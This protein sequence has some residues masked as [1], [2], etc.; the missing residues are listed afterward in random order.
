[1]KKTLGTLMAIV[2]AIVM[3]FVMTGCAD[4]SGMQSELNRLTETVAELTDKVN[5]LTSENKTLTDQVNDLSTEN[6]TLTDKVGDL[7]TDVNDLTI[8]NGALKDRVEGLNIF[9]TD[10]AEYGEKETMTVYFKNQAVLKIRLR[11]DNL[12]GASLQ[13]SGETT[14]NSSIYITSLFADIYVESILGTSYVVWEDGMFLRRQNMNSSIADRN[15]EELFGGQYDGSEEAYTNAT[16]FD[17]VICVPGTPFE[18]AR[19]KNVSVY[20][21]Q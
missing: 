11:L 18:L 17:F 13:W 3:V 6:K 2:M 16:W 14:F 5:D 20:K 15:E 4:T 19:F 1:M 21:P 8:E 10:K 7:T 9:T 12:Y